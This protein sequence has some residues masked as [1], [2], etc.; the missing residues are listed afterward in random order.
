MHIFFSGG[1]FRVL[2]RGSGRLWRRD[3]GAQRPRPHVREKDCLG[4]FKAVE[5][6]LQQV[7]DNA[8]NIQ[9]KIANQ[10]FDA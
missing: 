10:A 2:S 3:C 4:D 1:N 9:I 5:E 7:G 6:M 8:F